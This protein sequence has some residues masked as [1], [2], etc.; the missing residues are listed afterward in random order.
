MKKLAATLF[1]ELL[2]S[3]IVYRIAIRPAVRKAVYH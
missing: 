3:D 1:L 2:I